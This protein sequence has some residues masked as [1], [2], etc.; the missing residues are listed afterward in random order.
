METSPVTV[1]EQRAEMF[2]EFHAQQLQAQT[3]SL[4]TIKTLMIL[5]FVLT[6]VGTIPF[7]VTATLG[8]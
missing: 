3:K 7:L 1:E 8:S 6:V 5:W 2:R 4:E